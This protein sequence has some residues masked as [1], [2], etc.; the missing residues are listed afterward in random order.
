MFKNYKNVVAKNYDLILENFFYFILFIVPLLTIIND[1]QT[2]IRILSL[3][4]FFITM[5]LFKKNFIKSIIQSIHNNKVTATILT[6]FIISITISFI[7]SPAK[8]EHWGYRFA[9]HRY[10]EFIVYFFFFISVYDY[11]KNTNLNFKKYIKTIIYSSLFMVS[12][13]YTQGL[14]K[15]NTE[16]YN[17]LSLYSEIRGPGLILTSFISCFLGFLTLKNE[18]KINYG[19]VLI[20]SFLLSLVYFFGGRGNLLSIIIICLISL[21]YKKIL[22]ENTKILIQY[23]L[24]SFIAAYLFLQLIL[25]VYSIV[26]DSPPQAQGYKMLRS[27]SSGRIDVWLAAIDQFKNNIFFGQGPNIFYILQANNMLRIEGIGNER[28]IVHPHNFILQFFV[29]WGICGTLLILF[30]MSKNILIGSLNLLKKQNK[31]LLIPVFNILGLTA[32]GI[33]DS[34]YIHPVTVTYLLISNAMIAANVKFK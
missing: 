34:T 33:T 3:Q 1:K 28:I 30:L 26:L 20:L 9:R 16:V 10:L 8:V 14:F 2:V 17:L 27:G 7:L 19:N 4:I 29:E 21:I 12:I 32:H 15:N 5:L 24:I 25:F 31:Y 23:I 22:N 13:I 18:N 11:F 6:L